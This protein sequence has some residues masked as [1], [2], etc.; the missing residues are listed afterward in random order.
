[1]YK[2]FV[3]VHEY[4]IYLPRSL[5][6]LEWFHLPGKTH[7]NTCIENT[8]TLSM[9]TPYCMHCS[10]QAIFTIGAESGTS[11]AWEWNTHV[12]QLAIVVQFEL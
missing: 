2:D 11:V 10:R 5:P 9:P 6:V 1:M 8:I 12:V 7:Q 4:G 3:Y